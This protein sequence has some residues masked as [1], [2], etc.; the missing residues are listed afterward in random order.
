MKT[1]KEILILT[2]KLSILKIE[3]TSRMQSESQ[4]T[5]SLIQ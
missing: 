2:G 3:N 4:N 1:V 5:I